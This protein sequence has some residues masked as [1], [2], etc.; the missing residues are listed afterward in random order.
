MRIYLVLT[1]NSPEFDERSLSNVRFVRLTGELAA[2]LEGTNTT[3]SLTHRR[4]WSI[5][6][7]LI[8]D[9]THKSFSKLFTF[10]S[11]EE[12]LPLSIVVPEIVML[13]SQRSN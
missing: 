5:N 2:Q 4:S 12:D 1:V 13:L 7:C 11:F 3:S 8:I 10:N 9:L 6:Y